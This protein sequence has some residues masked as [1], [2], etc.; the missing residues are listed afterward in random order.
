MAIKQ[1]SINANSTTPLLP[2]EG[3]L[4]VSSPTAHGILVAEGDSACVPKVLTNGQLLVGSTGA[5]P[6]ATSITSAGGS[7][8]VTGGPGTINIAV[9]APL[10]VPYGGTGSTTLTSHGVLLGNGTS[11]VTATAAPTNGQLVIGSTGNAPALATITAGT[12]ITVT[13]GA[14]TISIASSGGGGFTSINVQTF[15]SSGTYTPT[16]GMLQCI[17]EAVGGGGGGGSSATAPLNDS[18]AAGAGGGAAAYAK[19]LFSAATVGSSLTI[20]IGA[21]GAGVANNPGNGG[22]NTVV[23]TVGT[24]TTILNA[25][26]GGGG[27]QGAAPGESTAP[28]IATGGTGGGLSAHPGNIL[29]LPGGV[30]GFSYSFSNGGSDAYLLPGVGG[31]SFY[32]AGGAVTNNPLVTQIGTTGF[33][34][35]SGGSGAITIGSAG[36]QPG[37]TGAA[38]IVI[39][40]EYI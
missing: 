24:V 10:N 31:N 11:P 36:D 39:I 14:G 37:G 34:Y 20:S 33:G 3:G 19:S 4:G 17:I 38:G 13:N 9:A 23:N 40:T 29:G 2:I 18:G 6:V 12:G 26:A 32:G 27:Y 35:G 16:T 25:S 21:G 7:L 22:G 8:N 28:T 5:D 15:T 30:G 1:N